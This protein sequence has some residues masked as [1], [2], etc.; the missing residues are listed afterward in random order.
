MQK[1]SKSTT[2]NDSQ[3]SILSFLKSG[4]SVEKKKSSTNQVEPKK[5]QSKSKSMNDNNH[6]SI[7]LNDND[8]ETYE[9]DSL[10]KPQIEIQEIEMKPESSKSSN[11]SI[12]VKTYS[13]K[14]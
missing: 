10:S 12:V 13:R 1:S 14:G 2:K 9:F 5:E 6:K 3:S 4:N 11:K 8:Q 7:S